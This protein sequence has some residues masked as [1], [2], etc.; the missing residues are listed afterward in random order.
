MRGT[1]GEVREHRAEPNSVARLLQEIVAV[2]EAVGVGPSPEFL[3]AAKAGL[4]APDSTQTSSMY[5]D[6]LRGVPIEADQIIG[7]SLRACSRGRNRD[8]AARGNLDP[9]LC[10]SAPGTCVTKMPRLGKSDLRL[11]HRATR[12]AVPRILIA[13]APSAN[14]VSSLFFRCGCMYYVHLVW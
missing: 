2:A 14:T 3:V 1:I 6:L 5:R 12:E 10:L 4:T 7:D 11:G 9:S 13:R 8:A